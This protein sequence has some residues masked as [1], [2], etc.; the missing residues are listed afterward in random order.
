MK[1]INE[2]TTVTNVRVNGQVQ[3]TDFEE[4]IRKIAND[5]VLEQPQI[6]DYALTLSQ[7]STR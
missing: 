7:V 3:S 6:S 2:V 1:Q 5:A 4:F